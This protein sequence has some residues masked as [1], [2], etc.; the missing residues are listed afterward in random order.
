MRRDGR[1]QSPST[2]VAQKESFSGS[3]GSWVSLTLSVPGQTP[4]R[5]T[6][7]SPAGMVSLVLAKQGCKSLGWPQLSKGT[8]VFMSNLSPPF[9]G[10]RTF[11]WDLGMHHTLR[12]PA[13]LESTRIDG[14]I[15]CQFFN[16]TPISSSVRW[17]HS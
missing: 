3:S 16:C 15:L 1:L 5:S 13:D 8:L 12:Q 17:G 4:A 2:Y 11:L 14:G 9:L 6:R 10:M 7:G